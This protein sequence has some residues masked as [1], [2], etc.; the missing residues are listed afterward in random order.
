MEVKGRYRAHSR[1]KEDLRIILAIA[2]KDI[3]IAIKDKQILSQVVTL[4]FIVIAYQLMP[5]IE[6]GSALP[7]MAVYDAGGSDLVSEMMD[8]PQF[9]LLE[10]SS[11]EGMKNYLGDRDQV[12][13]GLVVPEDF[14]QVMA[15]MD[16]IELEGY[17]VH[18]ASAAEVADVK[19]FFEG[20]LAELTGRSVRINLE[21]N[22]VFTRPDSKGLAFLVSLTM[23]LV[24]LLAGLFVVPLLM[25][26]EKRTK[27]VDS[28]LVSPAGPNHL[29]VGKALSG[30]FYMLAAATLVLVLNT[31]LITHWW[32]AIL[33]VLCGSLFAVAVGLLVGSIFEVRQQLRIWSFVLAS[34]LAIPV[35]I[36]IMEEI[37]PKGLVTIMQ[38]LPPVAFTKV[39]RASFSASAPIGTF[40]PGLAIIIGATVL[41]NGIMVWVL[42]R[43]DK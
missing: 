25:V 36:S 19:M 10:T 41:V 21:G 16:L 11:H 6:N 42:R 39:L 15:S 3:V 23:V 35:F 28:L 4:V 38:F 1:F 9:D 5:A 40:A 24:L 27:T 14:D 32:L 22:T 13:L 37:L 8:N 18:W 33:T 17:V 31:H 12:V 2:A 34:V 29:V 26:E 30:L 7:R 20:Q 43:S